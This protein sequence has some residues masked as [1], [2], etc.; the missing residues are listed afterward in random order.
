MSTKLNVHLQCAGCDIA[1]NKNG[2]KKLVLNGEEANSFSSCLKRTI[3]VNDILCHRCRLSIY[4]KKESENDSEL[5]RDL[6]SSEST[7]DP[8]FEVQLQPKEAMP[9][10]EYIEI[11]IQRTV[12][13]HK[14]CCICS[15]TNNLTVIPEEARMQSYIKKKIYIPV[16]NRCCRS[17]VIKNR[18]FEEDLNLLK[19]YSNTT[20][21]TGLEL[22]KLMGTLS[23]KCDS[24]LLDKVGEF[25]LS[26]QQL[27]VFTGL[28]WDNLIQIKDMMVSLR[29]S[30]SRSVIQALVVFLLK[31]RTGNSNKMIASILQLENEQSVSD[32]STSIIKSFEN[33]ILPFHFGLHAVNREDLIQNHNTEITKKLFDVCDN[34]FLICDGTY[35]RHQKSTN[36]EYQRK[37]FS[38]QK[39]VP[40]C[41]PFTICT[42]DGYIVDMLGPY[43]ANQNDAEILKNIIQ[44][45]NGL[46]KLLLKGD[47]FVLDRGFRDIVDDLEKKKFKVLMPALK[48]K[49]KQLST[50]ESNQSRF[51]TK[52]RWAVESVHGV[53]K[54]KYRLLDHK[55]DNKLI[56]K[57]GVYFRIASF[58]NNTFGKRLQSDV[59]I[60][61]EIVQRMHDQ[62]DMENTLAVE[63]EEKGWFRRKLL[64]QSITTNDLLD[65]PEMTERDM[66][67]LFTGSYQLSQAVSY[68]A[69]MVDKNGRLN[70]E[71]VKDETNVLKLK[72]PSRHI[73]R[74]TYRCFL[75]YKP[76]SIGVSGVT[77]YACECANG[78]RTVGCCSHI[79][80]IIYYLSY[81]RYLSKIFKPAEILSNIFKKDNS[82]PVIESNSDND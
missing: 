79:A 80:A 7:S 38:G 29:N 20:S 73:S 12:S 27:D 74:T 10:V 18:I 33:D 2:R 31:L 5:E 11:P 45:P 25:T 28:T 51:V 4:R 24:T 39:K 43:F 81:A 13:T 82:I 63:A 64:F 14:Y 58:L 71:Y 9:E 47:T 50:K 37:S 69:E 1:L 3:S 53:L 49:R 66:K 52:I 61:D 16:G 15:S 21:L 19:I 22:S 68:L 32:Y 23:I 77:D 78:R 36:N 57:V 30:K 46:Y 6:P 17:H 41:K 62:K 40:L 26:K 54:Q 35:A 56:P 76:N 48:G 60:E 65:F 70:V 75:R 67:V 55:I 44:D 72:V 8:I 59:E 42:T 34:L